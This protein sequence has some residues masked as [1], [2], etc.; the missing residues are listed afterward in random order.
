MSHRSDATLKTAASLLYSDF[1]HQIKQGDTLGVWT[2]NQQLYTG[3]MPLQRWSTPLQH[4]IVSDTLD[5]LKGQK[6]EK[7]PAYSSIRPALDK[8]IK[9]SE[10]ITVVLI[11]SGEDGISGTP[12]DDKINELYKNWKIDQEKAK[13]PFITVLRAKRGT[14]I[15]YVAVPVPWQVEIPPWPVETN[16]AP[17]VMAASPAKAQAA[18]PQALIFT[19]KKSKPETTNS[20]E[21]GA[22]PPENPPAPTATPSPKSAANTQVGSPA[23]EPSHVVPEKPPT[24]PPPVIEQKVQ[25]SE[26]PQ[27]P[28]DAAPIPPSNP[29]ASIPSAKPES[30]S[31]ALANTLNESNSTPAETRQKSTPPPQA[32][33]TANAIPGNSLLSNK[34]IWLAGLALLGVMCAI[35]FALTRRAPA[36][37]LSLITRSLERETK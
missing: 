35:L 33:S 27:H 20:P 37:H 13:M 36:E 1:S 6:Y 25:Q 3:R 24:A 4:E 28:S 22:A 29:V 18:P 34:T 11:S 9:D 32:I 12:F 16:A 17:T 2:Y 8:V 14:I 15:G 7:Q 26:T 19:G 31:P 30:A 10:F 5:F 21:A 23:S